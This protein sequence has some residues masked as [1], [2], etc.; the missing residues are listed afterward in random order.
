MNRPT[1]FWQIA[2]GWMNFSL[3]VPSIYL[4]LGLPLIMRQYGWSGT[5]IGL[6]QLAALPTLAKFLFALPVQK[7]NLGKQSFSIWLVIL[8]LPSIALL[9]W[10]SAHNLIEQPKLLFIFALCLSILFTWLDIPL[11]ALAAQFFLR[12]EQMYTG[13]I[14]SAAL[15]IGA[16]MGGGIFVFIHHHYGWHVPFILMAS[17]LLVGLIPLLCIKLDTSSNPQPNQR[18]HIGLHIFQDWKSF[19]NQPSAKTWIGLLLFGFPFIGAVWLYLKPAFLDYGLSVNVVALTIG[20]LGGIAGA[21]SSLIAPYFAKRLGSE[22]TILLYLA[23]SILAISALIIG[24][25]F[26]F[27]TIWLICCALLIGIGMGGIS[28]LLFGL[29]LLFCRK[30]LSATDYGLQTSLFTLSRILV[31]I[32]SGILFDAYGYII[33]FTVLLIAILMTLIMTWKIKHHLK[34]TLDH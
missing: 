11:N 10:L 6:F 33:M 24:F 2:F 7:L 21:I 27:S 4:M 23:I 34:P 30:E 13:S 14:R 5:E 31:P 20:T 26:K 9:C 22:Q 8:T 17:F 32:L 15:F 12:T 25:Y 29:T 1:L 28:A 3:A 19:F 16:I 18:P